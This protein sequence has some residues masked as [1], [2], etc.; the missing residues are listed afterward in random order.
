MK[1]LY[2]NHWNVLLW[3]SLVHR[4]LLL[5]GIIQIQHQATNKNFSTSMGSVFNAALLAFRCRYTVPPNLNPPSKYYCFLL[6][7]SKLGTSHVICNESQVPFR[8][9]AAPSLR[10]DAS[11]DRWKP[12][13][14]AYRLTLICVS[15]V[16]MNMNMY[17]H[18]LTHT[19]SLSLGFISPLLLHLVVK[20]SA[21]II[22][23]TNNFIPTEMYKD[24]KKER[25]VEILINWELLTPR[26]SSRQK[27][28]QWSI[29][30]NQ[31]ALA[32]GGKLA[33]TASVSVS[34]PPGL[35]A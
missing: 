10:L 31:V 12:L 26:S 35:T 22:S 33:V 30:K 5:I 2:Q 16:K 15:L 27:L 1:H 3:Y 32:V 6:R 17:T 24:G 9:H 28:N 34:C 13:V 14:I 18:T 7:T 25:G 29:W 23:Q 19:V 4:L 8:V 20:W 21:W 11:W